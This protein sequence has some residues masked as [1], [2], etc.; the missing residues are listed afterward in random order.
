[1]S[2][3]TSLPLIPREILHQFFSLEAKEA[4][5]PWNE[6]FQLWEEKAGRELLTHLYP[7]LWVP[8]TL[9]RQGKAARNLTASDYSN[10]ART[11]ESGLIKEFFH[12]AVL[13]VQALWKSFSDVD[14]AQFPAFSIEEAFLN[15][16]LFVELIRA[17]E[18]RLL[19]LAKGQIDP[20]IN[21]YTW[22]TQVRKMA[23]T[24]FLV[25]SHQNIKSVP[26][27][28]G[29]LKV[30]QA[31]DLKANELT[32]LPESI[33][34][35]ELLQVLDLSGNRLSGLPASIGKLFSLR[36]LDLSHNQLQTLPMELLQCRSLRYIYLQGNKELAQDSK[37]LLILNSL[38]KRGCQIVCEEEL[39][40]LFVSV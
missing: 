30:L 33:G 18:N 5:A 29:M 23:E 31:I 36:K 9:L 16:A 12:E 1:M 38:H 22:E 19:Q 24:R 21:G 25:L 8:A 14:R 3:D 40:N 39:K 35:L 28:I 17:D 10:M 7:D 34:N 13:K 32:E 15:P 11:G 27:S 6:T 2:Q 4:C 26:E 20:S 37:T